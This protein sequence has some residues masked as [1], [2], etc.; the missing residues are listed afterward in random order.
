[1]NLKREREREV[2]K[3]TK[4]NIAKAYYSENSVTHLTTTSPTFGLYAVNSSVG[5]ARVRHG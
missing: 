5:A 1:M 2:K 3:I 4:S